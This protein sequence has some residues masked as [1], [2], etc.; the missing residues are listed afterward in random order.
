MLM[1]K[2]KFNSS[3]GILILT[4]RL[5]EK[6]SA[7]LVS[8]SIPISRNVNFVYNFFVFVNFFIVQMLFFSYNCF[9][10]CLKYTFIISKVQDVSE[11]LQK[12]EKAKCLRRRLA[13]FRN[14]SIRLQTLSQLSHSLPCSSAPP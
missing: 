12:V 14:G 7:K 11:K 10:G 1:S 8:S 2:S 9:L 3:K 6:T 5:Y 4:D 13:Q